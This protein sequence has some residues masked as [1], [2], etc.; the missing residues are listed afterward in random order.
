MAGAPFR[1]GEHGPRL[2]PTDTGGSKKL[3]MEAAVGVPR[4]QLG[5]MLLS[6]LIPSQI[7][8]SLFTF[9]SCSLTSNQASD[10]SQDP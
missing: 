4:D 1:A 10:L 2:E 3:S 9:H 5:S 8:G 7:I 6:F